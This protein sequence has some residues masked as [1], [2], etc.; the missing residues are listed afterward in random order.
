MQMTLPPPVLRALSILDQQG[1]SAYVVGGCVRDAV[2]GTPPHD[3]DMC[4]S[5][6]P[7]EMQRVFRRFRTLETGLRHGTLT[8]LMDGMPLEITTFRV[9]GDYAD[10]RHPDSVSFTRLVEDDL[11]RRDLTVNA[12]AFNPREGLVDPFHG[13]ADCRA[14]IIR[15]VGEPECRF[16]EDALRIL[17]ALRFS[18]RLGFPIEEKTG[19][20]LLRMRESLRLVSAERIA[21]ELNGLLIGK[22]AHQVLAAYPEVLFTVL[23]D[24][25]AM[26]N[27][28]QQC[29]YHDKDVW[30]HTLR[31]V[32]SIPREP[33]LRWAALMH[34][35]A[36]PLFRVRD[37]QGDDHFTGHPEKGAEMAANMLRAL[38]M[39]ARMTEQVSE[40]VLWH[41][42]V[43]E[44]K[45]VQWL[46][47]RLG[48][49]QTERLLLLRRADLTAHAP[50][51]AR[52]A[53]ENYRVLHG[54]M[55]AL[56]RENAC[57]SLRQLAVN[58]RDL[59]ALGIRGALIGETLAR[60]LDMVTLGEA[61]NEKEA[62][63]SVARQAL[64]N[65]KGSEQK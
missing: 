47:S 56:L 27:C 15:C 57:I 51:I 54:K 28:P 34:D 65:G 32:E 26:K 63:L 44:E 39:P 18:A 31:T 33:L 46:L 35:C 5:A 25:A 19:E 16:E 60:M 13:E 38:K 6:R 58:G 12:M 30:T 40:L 14:G 9:D 49:E 62:L 64:E 29:V 2:L 36:K 22:N 24:L 11:A 41:D 45:D 23:P 7:E 1:F 20:A 3:Y 17:R 10:H 52:N 4:T 8:V 21:A 61:A 42:R 37:A 48:A 50:W 53:E 59:T 55:E 43:V